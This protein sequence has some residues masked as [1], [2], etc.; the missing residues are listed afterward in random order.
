MT[1]G[2]NITLVARDDDILGVT[3]RHIIAQADTLPDLTRVV[4]LLPDLQ[5][6]PRLR[7]HLLQQAGSRGFTA[8]L[9]PAISTLDVWLS[10]TWPLAADVPGRARREMILVE[11]LQQ[12]PEV[13]RGGNPWQIAA[14]LVSLFDELTVNR[15]SV[16]EDV[17]A[18]TERLCSAYGISDRLPEP[19]GMEATVVHQLWMA[20]HVQLDAMHMIDPGV[21]YLEKLALC[22]ND[23]NGQPVIIAGFD[24]PS[25]T[26]TDWIVSMLDAGKAHCLLYP[27]DPGNPTPVS[28]VLP[29]IPPANPTAA[30]LDAIFHTREAPMPERA[31]NLADT[32]PDSPLAGHLAV[33]TARSPEQE[34]RAIDLQVRQWLLEERNPIGI[35]T[36]DR[37]LARRV[38][39]L[40]ERAG[41]ELQDSGGW[42]LSTT[43]AAAALERWLETVEEDFAH[44]PLLDVLKSPFSYP[45][46]DPERFRTQVYR[47]EQD[48]IHHESISR[49]LDRYRRHIELRR[50]RLPDTWSDETPAEL[51]RLLNRLD[52]AA[53]PLREV[54]GEKQNAPAE[55]LQ[56]LRESLTGLGMWTGFEADPA[57][58]RILQEWQLLYEAARHSNAGMGWTEF[59][60]WL[61]AALERHDFRPASSNTP[62]ML[63]T[64]GQAQL[65]SFAGLVIGACDREH[66]P[67]RSPA[68]PFF[69]DPVR[70]ELGLPTWPQRAA[71]Q[72]TRFRRLLESAPDVLMT[73]HREANGEP[74]MPSP[75]LDALQT[76]HRL[77]WEHDLEQHDLLRQVNS[78]ETRV[79][80]HNPA[81]APVP[82]HYPSAVLPGSLLPSSLSV[83]AHGDLVD[84]P[85]RFFSAHGLGLKPKEAVSEALQKSGYGEKVHL[86]LEIFHHGAAGWPE[87]FTGPVSDANRDAAIRC[88]ENISRTVFTRD[89]EDNFEHRAWLRR[90]TTRIPEYIDWQ[91][92]HQQD[93]KVS[94]AELRAEIQLDKGRTLKG[95]LDRV[96][97]GPAGESII[98]Y[99]TGS[100]PRQEEVDEGEKVQLPSYALLCDHFPERVEYL[101]L[102]KRVTSGAALEGAA[103]AELANAVRLRL[104]DVLRG[105][106]TGTPLPAWGDAGTCRYCEMDALCRQQAWLEPEETTETESRDAC[107]P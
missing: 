33:C 106:E 79:R 60:A 76:F 10:E 84:C 47:L 78:E 94:R 41:I 55:L 67:V 92:R 103:L 14:S 102:D 5:F 38:R 52:Q 48:I 83:S 89:L 44:Q 73:W 25:E 107:Q 75:W 49:G 23:W 21:A 28:K 39:A 77:G 18:F 36:E 91:I 13:F 98:D 58:Q 17:I 3:A 30:C 34:A 81:P 31:R 93:W 20:W 82:G 69:N 101:N 22:R 72:L 50:Q 96:D 6:A 90:W 11:V 88:L 70:R 86:C 61:G 29:T 80:G 51:Q 68:S 64:I 1:T 104:V 15:V 37:R 2:S 59:R 99:K 24:N 9:G 62:V 45:D 95:R 19:L 74:R 63:L 87:P 53:D 56:R 4:V 42:A 35:V 7:R 43:S 46:D 71:L 27:Q 16:P 85:Y 32:Y 12:H 66:L 65:G 54:L 100:S 57:G 26:E 40:L 97:I 105:I 8:L